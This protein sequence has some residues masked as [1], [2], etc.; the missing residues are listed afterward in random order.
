MRNQIQLT[1]RKILTHKKCFR[2]IQ[3]H[4]PEFHWCFGPKHPPKKKHGGFRCCWFV[5]AFWTASRLPQNMIITYNNP[6]VVL[7]ICHAHPIYIYIYLHMFLHIQYVETPAEGHALGSLQKRPLK[8]PTVL[9]ETGLYQIFQQLLGTFNAPLR[10]EKFMEMVRQLREVWVFGLVK[11][12]A[13]IMCMDNVG[14][15]GGFLKW[16]VSP[17]TMGFIY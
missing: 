5:V 11:C 9:E 3:K 8:N 1:E 6:L 14:I 13:Y 15:H 4:L 10:L 16:W 2:S 12:D 17:T 7:K